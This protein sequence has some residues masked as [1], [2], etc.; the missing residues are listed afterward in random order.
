M[1]RCKRHKGV[2][3]RE[4]AT[5]KD[6]VS[7]LENTIVIYKD[8][9]DNAL[10]QVEFRKAQLTKAIKGLNEI[11]SLPDVDADHRSVIVRDTLKAIE[12]GSKGLI[13]VEDEW[14]H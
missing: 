14:H 8:S 4:I 13:G 12:G 1:A 3:L 11:G 5:L 7:R 6:K 9:A 2:L 10:K